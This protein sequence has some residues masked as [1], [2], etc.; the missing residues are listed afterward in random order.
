MSDDLSK[1]M[2]YSVKVAVPS[3]TFW[4]HRWKS[5]DWFDDSC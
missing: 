5:K 4:A 2:I 1:A 3:V